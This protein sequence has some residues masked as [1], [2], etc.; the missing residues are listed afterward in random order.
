MK[1]KPSLVTS[2]GTPVWIDGDGPPIVL[3]HGVLMDH[4]MWEA[5]VNALSGQYRVCRLDMLGH[6]LAADPP[7]ERSLSDF[8]AQLDEV[9]EQLDLHDKPI[10][11]GFSMGGLIAQAYA[12]KHHSRLRGLMILNAVYDRSAEQVN[13]VRERSQQMKAAGAQ[14]AIDSAMARWFT[15]DEKQRQAALVEQIVGWIRDGEFAPKTKAHWV[16]ATSDAQ[17]V[18]ILGAI[19]CPTLV[20]TGDSDAGSTPQ[21]AQKIASEIPNAR[22]EVLDNQRHMMPVLDAERVNAVVLDFVTSIPA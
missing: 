3:A 7:G 13:I 6:G 8:V 20:M 16:F 1:R 9:I 12:A 5:Q 14:G 17:V 22:L 10:L 15:A 4:R 2:H 18:G 19:G 21:M 11:G